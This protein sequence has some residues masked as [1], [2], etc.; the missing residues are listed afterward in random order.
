MKSA[1]VT[2][3]NG[4]IGSAVIKELLRNNVNV[5]A[6]VHKNHKDK[7]PEDSNLNIISCELDNISDLAG[8][9][10]KNKFEVFYHFAWTGSTGNARA[11]YNLQLKNAEWTVDAVN[12]AGELGCKRFVGA[13]TLAEHDV[14]AYSPV[15]GSVPNTVS[16]YGTAKIAAHY[17]SKAECSRLGIE[18]LWAYLPNTFGIGNY[19]SN[20]INFAAKIMI[21]GKRADFTPGE[22]LYDF[23]YI[24]D[25]AYGL[26][27][28]GLDGK[29]NCSYY[30]GS[31]KYRKLKEYIKLV[32]DAIDPAIQ[33]NL[34]AIPFNGI[35][36]PEELFDC[37]KL[38]NDTGYRP[39]ITFEE[40]LKKT[41]PWIRE[42]IQGGIL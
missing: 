6:I 9:I 25:T 41:I 36:Q 37:S 21:T 17:M 15:D 19:T 5:C 18:H 42:Q 14:Q 39:K 16:H 30:I 35:T 33:L 28:I 1:I 24:S 3:A 38:V 26:Y 12:L 40:G 22:Q 7:L 20:F 2:G 8:Q 34:G 23:L 27:C 13:G 31:L 29:K 11:D 32:R 4:F 10:E